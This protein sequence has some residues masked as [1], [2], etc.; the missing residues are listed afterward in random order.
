MAF[1]ICLG[2]SSYLLKHISLKVEDRLV[3]REYITPFTPILNLKSY[4]LPVEL[5]LAGIAIEAHVTCGSHPSGW[6][7]TVKRVETIGLH[8]RLDLN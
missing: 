4:F 3:R 6:F 5:S 7:I 1:F 2:Q 8:D